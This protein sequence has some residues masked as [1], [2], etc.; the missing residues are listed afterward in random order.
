MAGHAAAH[1]E[2]ALGHGHAAEVFGRSLDADEH[3]FALFLGPCLGIVGEEHDLAGGSARRCGKAFGNYCGAFEGSLVK[4]R[5]EKFV[6]FCRFHAQEGGLFVDSACAEEVHGYFHHSGTGAFAVTGLEHPELAVLNGEFHVLHIFVV[7]FEL[8]GNSDK[9]GGA[10]RH[11][12]LK[13]G[14]FRGTFIFRDALQGSPTTRAFHCDLLGGAD[15]GNDIFA[16]CVDEVFA[17]ENVLTGRCIAGESHTGSRVVAHV[18]INHG[19][20]IHGGAPFLGDLIHAAVDDGAFVHP[21]VEDGADAAPEL[22]PCRFGEILAGVFFDSGFEEFHKIAEIFDFEFGVELHALLFL[23]FIDDS[24]KGVGFGFGFGFHAE[25]HVAIHLHE[26]A[27]A[28][29]GETGIATLVGKRFHGSVVH[30]EIEDS[31]HHAGHRSAGAGAHGNEQRVIGVVEFVAGEVFN[32]L[33]SFFDISFDIFD[34]IIF[35]IL[36]VFR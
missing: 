6:E 23:D 5:V 28:V 9:L 26:A 25:N 34:N 12:F 18:A 2:D 27:I 3:H 15:A 35:A 21:A 16:L 7:V 4:N 36:G 19:L 14:I 30:A 1:C 8:V 31:V 10:H 29:P 24:L 32:V 22:I 33:D 11:R 20:D 13:R 17:V